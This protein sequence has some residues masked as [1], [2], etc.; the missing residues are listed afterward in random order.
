M[1]NVSKLNKLLKFYFIFTS[2]GIEWSIE[3]DV[4]RKISTQSRNLGILKKNLGISG[5]LY[6]EQSR[7]LEF[8]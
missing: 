2:R 1:Q 5:S 7:S 4:S 6:V 3:I 8:L